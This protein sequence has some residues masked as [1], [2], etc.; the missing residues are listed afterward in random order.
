MKKSN[1]L[2]KKTILFSSIVVTLG[3]F[4][5]LLTEQ[6]QLSFSQKEMRDN[7]M[8]FVSSNVNLTSQDISQNSF[9]TLDDISADAIE[10]FSMGGLLSSTINASEKDNNIIDKTDNNTEINTTVGNLVNISE[11]QGG[12]LQHI[13]AG[14][15]NLV[16]DN[17]NVQQFNATFKM[18]KSN[19]LDEKIYQLFNFRPNVVIPIVLDP[20]AGTKFTGMMDVLEDG[21]AKWTGVQTSVIIGRQNTI[22]IFLNPEMTEYAFYGKPIYGIVEKLRINES[23][24]TS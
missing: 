19:G 6:P 8:D 4:I 24:P 17:E 10:T 3:S 18:V 22:L 13:I 23:L 20:Q 7:R 12:P 11:I 21:E 1:Q 2:Y 15:W 5:L 16:V 14:Y 9:S